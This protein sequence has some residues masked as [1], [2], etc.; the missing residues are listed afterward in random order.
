MAETMSDDE[1]FYVF[2]NMY[3]DHKAKSV[4]TERKQLMFEQLRGSPVVDPKRIEQV[5]TALVRLRKDG[6]LDNDRVVVGIG[7]VTYATTPQIA[8][9]GWVGVYA[10]V[11]FN[12]AN[13]A[14]NAQAISSLIYYEVA[15]VM[16]SGGSVDL[17]TQH[18]ELRG[19]IRSVLDDHSTV[20]V[21]ATHAGSRGQ[22]VPAQPQV[23]EL[24]V[25]DLTPLELARFA[26]AYQKAQA[27]AEH[28][29]SVA[30]N[31]RALGIGS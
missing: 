9:M 18:D 12:P 3:R 4:A 11:Q 23:A 25:G 20:H 30:R 26:H 7:P 10:L 19:V 28:Y 29:A 14:A 6:D 16:A 13:F 21:H 8:W 2:R 15:I 1:H 31:A 22:P 27:D 5:I 24:R 17:N